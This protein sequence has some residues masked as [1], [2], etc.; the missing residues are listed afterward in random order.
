MYR[1]WLLLVACSSPAAP[2]PPVQA[3]SKKPDP[4][5][6]AVDKLTQT[7]KR[8]FDKQVT[9]DERTQAIESCRKA[10]GDATI[11][12]LVAAP[13]DDSVVT[14][15]TGP[16]GEPKDQLDAVVEKLRTYHFVHEHFPRTT[17]AL[18]PPQTCCSFPSKKCPAGDWSNETW[19][20]VGLEFTDEHQFQY[21]YDGSSKIIVVE[22]IGDPG[23]TGKLLTYRR[24]LELRADGKVHITIINPS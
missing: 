10:P 23:C 14:C 7:V 12:C 3:V 1:T 6:T 8:R 17:V 19:K 2:V 15:M 4:C 13:D 24:E 5:E 9:P 22:A 20:I 18:T 21:R 11:A 16:K